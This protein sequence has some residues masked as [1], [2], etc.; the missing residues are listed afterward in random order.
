MR[1]LD[2]TM[3]QAIQSLLT[4]V[5]KA[6][7]ILFKDRARAVDTN[8][9]YVG[10]DWA[11]RSPI[12]KAD[13]D[14]PK[15]NGN[16]YI[17]TR[18]IG[19]AIMGLP[20]S[21]VEIESDNGTERITPASDHPAMQVLRKPNA[22]HS[23]S[24]I[25]S[26][27]TKSYLTDGNA[28]CT[29]ERLT[30]PN[31]RIELWPRDPRN[32]EIGVATR[33]YRFGPYTTNQIIYPRE[34]V[35]HIRDVDTSNP[36]WGVGRVSTI[37]EEILLDYFITVFNKKFFEHGATLNLMFTPD[38]NLTEDQ[39][40]EILDALSAEVEGADNAFK[41][42]INR[43]A[44]KFEYPEQK[45]K[46][47]AFMQLLKHNREKM[48]GV[49]GLPP[50][51]GGVMEYANYANALQQDIDFWQNTVKPI[52]K[53]ITDAFNRQILWPIYGDNI[54]IEFDLSGIPAIQ[55]DPTA[56][57]DRLLKLKDKGIVSAEYVRTELNI[58][59]DAAP[60]KEEP[61][62]DGTP[63]APVPPVT[64][65]SQEEVKQALYKQFKAQRTTVLNK[66]RSMTM[67]GDFMA[68]LCDAES[69]V[70]RILPPVETINA[71]LDAVIPVIHTCAVL[72]ANSASENAL[73]EEDMDDISRS[74]TIHLESV[75]D[76]TYNLLRSIII[77][78]DK[79]EWNLDQLEKAVKRLF[80]FDRAS[81]IVK[82]L[83]SDTMNKVAL[84]QF[85][86]QFDNT[87]SV[88]KGENC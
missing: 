33:S 53:V 66:L 65:A 41:L 18:A 40:Q 11:Q 9:S 63:T 79:H 87:Q 81:A 35:L 44:G 71:M 12:A 6:G 3:G 7:L 75:N 36:Y 85:T 25:I 16:V 49:F 80:T 77:E 45:H 86:A 70:Y 61:T 4:R 37:R 60:K 62:P 24:D 78:S 73:K 47:I 17:A 29:V 74:L 58:S 52:L 76:Q 28:I 50:F 64:P 14:A 21:I 83:L 84:A 15:I 48:F 10:R 51:R 31:Q 34:N 59:E 55:G 68:V 26:H 32:V 19:E 42:F 8:K 13:L 43:Y 67:Q 5:N 27:I 56:K 54:C 88:N 38:F 82:V 23:W 22:E 39:H 69:Q 30:G 46:D 1:L 2:M 57:V 72:P 20:V